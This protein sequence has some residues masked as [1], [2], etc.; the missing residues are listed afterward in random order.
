VRDTTQLEDLC[1]TWTDD[2]CLRLSHIAHESCNYTEYNGTWQ[3]SVLRGSSGTGRADPPLPGCAAAPKSHVWLE[4]CCG[5]LTSLKT[6][7]WPPKHRVNWFGR[8]NQLGNPTSESSVGAPS[9]M[10]LGRG[11][12]WMAATKEHSAKEQ[13]RSCSVPVRPNSEARR[14][15][16]STTACQHSLWCSHR[17]GSVGKL[18]QSWRRGSSLGAILAMNGQIRTVSVDTGSF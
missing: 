7:C 10:L 16:P 9:G 1:T 2:L 18:S 5:P 15:P 8:A 14:V 17:L 13:E 6:G 11:Q 4:L 12:A 3:R